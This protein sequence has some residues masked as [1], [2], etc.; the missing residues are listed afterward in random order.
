MVAASPH[1]HALNDGRP[2]S[3]AARMDAIL[4]ERLLERLEAGKRARL[5]LLSAPAGSGKTTLLCDWLGR[6]D[7][8]VARVVL[9]PDERDP[10]RFW[11]RLIAA[12]RTVHDGFGRE[13]MPLLH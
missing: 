5:I 6:Q 10:V 8:H 7:A 4:R 9:S 13:I 2:P 12:V 3:R 1:S 11:M